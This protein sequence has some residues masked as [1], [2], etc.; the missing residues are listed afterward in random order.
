MPSMLKPNLCGCGAK[1]TTPQLVLLTERAVERPEPSY[2]GEHFADHGEN[3]HQ[4]K[5]GNSNDEKP[6]EP[7]K[8]H[9]EHGKT[10]ILDPL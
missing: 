7:V 8:H 4:S 6:S 2:C 10:S 3:H 9:Y 5:N 1:A